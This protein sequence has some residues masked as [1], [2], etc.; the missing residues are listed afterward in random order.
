MKKII[1]GISAMLLLTGCNSKEEYQSNINKGLEAVAED[2]FGKAEALFEIALEAK[3]KEESAKAYLEQVVYIQEAANAQEE[4]NIS[5]AIQALDKA[6]SVKNGSKVI[7]SKA[8]T[9]KEEIQVLQENNDKFQVLLG[10]AKS[11]TKASKYEKS[12][13]KLDNLL[14]QDLTNFPTIRDEAEKLKE[15]NNSAAKQKQE[16]EIA[17]QQ[18]EAKIA[19][20]K[21]AQAE[22]KAYDPY[23]WNPGVQAKFEQSMID[24]EYVDSIDTIRYEQ[25]G[26]YNNQGHYEVYGEFDGQEFRIVQVNVKTGDY[27]G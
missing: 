6:I 1:I 9:Q 8:E 11:L 7:S 12:I 25:S 24:N 16:A 21:K 15:E 10:E 5:D 22:K 20:Q 23:E 3:P 26:I 18:E 2:N 17:K 19:A 4:N 13:Q 14:A 27:H